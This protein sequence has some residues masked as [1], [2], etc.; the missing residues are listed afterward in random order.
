MTSLSGRVRDAAIVGLLCLSL[1]AWYGGL[2]WLSIACWVASALLMWSGDVSRNAWWYAATLPF[3][4]PQSAL[5]ARVAT[6][7]LFMLPLLGRECVAAMKHGIRVPRTTLALPIASLVVVFAVATIVGYFRMGHVSWWALLN[8]DAGLLLLAGTT[9]VLVRMIRTLEDA[10]RLARWFVGGVG[11]AN[12]T[13]LIATVAAFAG[14]SNSLYMVDNGRLYGWMLNPSVNGGLLFSAAMIEMAVLMRPGAPGEQRAW[15]WANVWFMALGLALTLSRSAWLSAATGAAVLFAAAAVHASRTREW[16]APQLAAVAVWLVLPVLVFAG[17]VRARGGVEVRQPEQQAASLQ[18]HLVKQCASH[19]TLEY[20][21]ELQAP[22]PPPVGSR[23]P[24]DAAATPNPST[25]AV[26]PVD[27]A[28]PLT[29]TRG[30]NDRVAI[31]SAGLT[32]YRR[33]VPS[34]LL[35]IGLGTFYAT[36][37]ATFGVPL[38]IHNTFIWF[39][40]ELGPIG[41]MV[42][43][44]FWGRTIVNLWVAAFTRNGGEYLAYGAMAALAGLTMFCLLNEGFYQR[45][46]WLVVALADRLHWLATASRAPATPSEASAA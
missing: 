36:S 20:C 22:A 14:Y 44:W 10:T 41:L 6:A 13:S 42:L 35:G 18:A 40:V 2:A 32:A 31:A 34:L 26:P 16:R 7:D 30:L 11:V 19:P 3:Q 17:I 25:E 29:N 39:L 43:L 33:D 37:A 24:A 21:R 9:L 8:K 23:A 1:A 12:I 45:Q 38:I 46:L 15:R 28:G 27:P 4:L 5:L